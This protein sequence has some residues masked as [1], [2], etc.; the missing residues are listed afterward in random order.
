LKRRLRTSVRLTDGDFSIVKSFGGKL[1][2]PKSV[3]QKK[4]NKAVVE[5]V[6]VVVIMEERDDGGGGGG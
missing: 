3:T 2:S 1:N 6:M 5:M 4:Q